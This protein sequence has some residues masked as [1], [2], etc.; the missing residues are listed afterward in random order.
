[1]N[2]LDHSSAQNELD[3]SLINFRQYLIHV[4]SKFSLVLFV[5]Q[6]KLDSIPIFQEIKN[7][8]KEN[9]NEEDSLNVGIWI[10]VNKEKT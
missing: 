7:L 9:L 6:H 3:K 2:L 10:S 1:M 5:F 4:N 8:V